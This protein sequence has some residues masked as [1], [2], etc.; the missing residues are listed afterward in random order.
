MA[1]SKKTWED[2]VSQYPNRRKLTDTTTSTIQTVTVARDEGTVTTVGDAFSAINMNNLES[3]ISNEFS[4]INDIL[5]SK[6]LGNGVTELWT[7]HANSGTITLSDSIRNY[8][9]LYTITKGNNSYGACYSI[10]VEVFINNFSPT[11][12]TGNYWMQSY[13]ASAGV[14]IQYT[15]DTTI[16]FRWQSSGFLE[17]VYGVKIWGG[18]SSEGG[19]S[20]G[21]SSSGSSSGSV[22][23]AGGFESVLLWTNSSPNAA[24]AAQ[25]IPLDL[26]DYDLVLIEGKYALE[27]DGSIFS[28][29]GR[30]GPEKISIACPHKSGS[31]GNYV[32]QF[33]AT[34]TGVQFYDGFLGGTGTSNSANVPWRIYGMKSSSIL[35]L[36]DWSNLITSN[37]GSSGAWTYTATQ[38]CY[39]YFAVSQN[40]STTYKMTVNGHD[41]SSATIYAKSGLLPLASGDILACSADNNGYSYYVFGIKVKSN[42][43]ALPENYSTTEQRIGTWTDGRPLYRK[44]ILDTYTQNTG[45][46]RNLD[47]SGVYQYIKV[48]VNLIPLATSTTNSVS[49]TPYYNSSSDYLYYYLSTPA[50][51]QL[52]IKGGSDWPKTTPI[53]IIVTYTK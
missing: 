47:I 15:T 50:T 13:Y 17:A 37:V 3:R 35:P 33:T 27:T 45:N 20:G 28:V 18:G 49:T 36:V 8:D 46:A 44:V 25:T 22:I 7:G 9:Y 29:I 24:F 48:E 53:A 6:V 10:P 30:I 21:G 14:G 11:I 51:G 12:G 38:D 34:S 31:G 4:N 43:S 2:R 5:S 19:S 32:R 26:S 23:G 42:S 39:V 16:T 52:T 40:S 1:Y 41:I